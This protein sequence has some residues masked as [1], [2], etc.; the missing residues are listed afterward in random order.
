MVCMA[1]PSNPF[2]QAAATAGVQ[3]GAISH[4]QARR[5]GLSDRQ[6]RGLVSR[7]AWERRARGIFTIAGSPA[8]PERATVVAFLAAA[9]AGG[10]VSHLSAAAVHGLAAH[11]PHPEI[12][13]PPTAS[14][15][16]RV[17]TVH[18][19]TVPPVDRAHR[20]PLVVTAVSRTLVDCAA[21]VDGPT[22]ESLFDAAFCRKLATAASVNAAADR[23]GRGRPGLGLAR[24]TAEVWNLHITPGSPAELRAIRLL[25]ELGLDDLVPQHEVF[26]EA[27]S[28]VARLDLASPS[29][30][31]GLEYDGVEFHGPRSWARDE[32]RYCRLRQAGWQVE[33]LD[34]LDLLPGEP[35]L[36]RL[37]SSW[38]A[39]AC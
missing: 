32:G 5:A 26:D 31:L 20:G 19:S 33:S 27:G 34:K 18:R 21:V 25:A 38:S 22:V 6:V 2:A 4:H 7:G 17:A 37:V 1:P 24:R 14:A 23:V 10:V 16:S 8:T 9:A 11:P 28:F 39:A 13:V 36:R 3:H 29:R 15:G 35:R 30:R 12:T